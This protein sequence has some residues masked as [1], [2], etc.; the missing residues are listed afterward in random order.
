MKLQSENLHQ[1]MIAAAKASTYEE[2]NRAIFDIQTLLGQDDGGLAG[3]CFSGC[4]DLHDD[5]GEWY[6]M[7][8]EDRFSFVRDYVQSELSHMDQEGGKA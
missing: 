3:V 4:N 5:N 7:S 1:A 2:A 6:S 8:I